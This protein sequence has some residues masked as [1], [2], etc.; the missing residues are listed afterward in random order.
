MHRVRCLSDSIR[1]RAYR[2]LKMLQ[3]FQIFATHKMLQKLSTL[4]VAIFTLSTGL[5]GS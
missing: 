1:V 3:N 4:N 5:K 2:M